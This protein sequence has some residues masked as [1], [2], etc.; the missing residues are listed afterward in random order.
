M[1][2]TFLKLNDTKT[3]IKLFFHKKSKLTNFNLIGETAKGPIKIL[4]TYL[5]DAWKFNDFI[6]RK[7]QTCNFHLRNLYNIRSS[8]D[9][10]TRILLVTNLILSTIDYCNI[11]LLGATDLDI[12]PLHLMI[13]RSLR[14]IYNVNYRDHISPYYKQA[15]F[16][17]I[18]KRIKFKACLIAFKI[19][20]LQT[21]TYFKDDFNRFISTSNMTLREGCGRDEFM[22]TID[23]NTIRSKKLS[24]LIIKEWNTLPI[25]LRKVTQISLFK[26]KLKSL[27]FS[28]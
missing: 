1:N 8:L 26:T 13:N 5:N 25:N 15:H 12:K 24:I 28:M 10:Q 19:F 9:T 16:L 18:R 17:P 20:H 2:S 14:F 21:P 4:G 6:T 22:F 23:G 3:I 27:L 7:I 11:L